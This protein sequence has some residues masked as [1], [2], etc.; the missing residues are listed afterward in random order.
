MRIATGLAAPCVA[1]LLAACGPGDAAREG[2]PQL[3]IAAAGDRGNT[4]DRDDFTTQPGGNAG[5]RLA[6]G[7]ITA[8]R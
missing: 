4:A 7:V 1:V 2:P 5:A 6:C 3:D 8:L